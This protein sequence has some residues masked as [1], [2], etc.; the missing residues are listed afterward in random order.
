MNHTDN[1]NNGRE[2]TAVASA[3][4]TK[5]GRERYIIVA[6]MFTYAILIGL[7]SSPGNVGA[8]L[9]ISVL[10]YFL[11]IYLYYGVATL[12]FMARNYLLWF[13]GIFA[14]VV[15]YSIAGLSGTWVMLTSWSMILASGA[16]VGR[17]SRTGQRQFKVYLIGLLIVSVFAVA[18]FLPQWKSLMSFGSELS[19]RL[20]QDTLEK[21]VA[22]G[23]G[24]DAVQKSLEGV[25]RMF[26]AMIRLIP[27]FTVLG[28]VL[29]FSVGY[30]A[31]AYRLGKTGNAGSTMAP[32]TLWKM[33]FMVMPILIVAAAMRLFGSETLALAA[34]NVL[35][36]LCLFYSVTG[37]ALIEFFLRKFNFSTILKILFYI[38]F[39]LSQFVGLFV[40]AFLG[41]V[42]SFVD[43]RKVQQLSL[44]RK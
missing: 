28:A 3:V 43:W 17:L 37:L 34:D 16:A 36:F 40:A 4:S 6:V 7:L 11:G 10:A 13:G 26:S 5:P 9:V 29:P 39:F 24:A 21:S 32:F 14:F 1:K 19:A 25:E 8:S 30:L 42:D 22:M 12:A 18:Q 2:D 23:Y 20:I 27:A 38:V 31:F 44:E 35:A 33:P 15:S 41:F